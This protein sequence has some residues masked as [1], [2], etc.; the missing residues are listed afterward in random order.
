VKIQWHLGAARETESWHRPGRNWMKEVQMAR[1]SAKKVVQYTRSFVTKFLTASIVDLLNA[2]AAPAAVQSPLASCPGV[3]SA[4]QD[5][6]EQLGVKE[7]VCLFLERSGPAAIE[8]EIEQGA[9]PAKRVFPNAPDSAFVTSLESAAR[10]LRTHCGVAGHF[11]ADQMESHARL[12][13]YWSITFD[14]NFVDA[15]A[16]RGNKEAFFASSDFSGGEQYAESLEE[17]AETQPESGESYVHCGHMDHGSLHFWLSP[18][19]GTLFARPDG[20]VGL[21]RWIVCCGECFHRAKG[22][23]E[24]LAIRGDGVW[25]ANTPLCKRADNPYE[26]NVFVPT[27]R[28]LKGQSPITH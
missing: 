24:M 19:D 5:P 27:A 14:T 2:H 17:H 3:Q 18:G 4:L 6:A 23:P 11:V 1:K 13:E 10:L 7:F 28:G 25:D 8:R 22:N 21:A 12:Y 26:P 15:C 20:S 9:V 16:Y